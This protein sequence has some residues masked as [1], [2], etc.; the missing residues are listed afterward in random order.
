MRHPKGRRPT[1]T[2]GGIEVPGDSAVFVWGLELVINPKG[3]GIALRSL[4]RP[5]GS[6][7]SWWPKAPQDPMR[8]RW[9]IV[10]SRWAAQS[11]ASSKAGGGK[12]IGQAVYSPTAGTEATR[13][14]L[15]LASNSNG[16]LLHPGVITPF[17]E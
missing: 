16:V 5:S 8:L 6:S 9:S 14:L 10:K 12:S 2:R 4:A 15:T 3:S 7:L 17:P 1:P 13:F 11:A